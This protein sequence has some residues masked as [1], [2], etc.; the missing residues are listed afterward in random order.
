MT[1]K[2]YGKPGADRELSIGVISVLQ[3]EIDK[4]VAARSA[5]EERWLADLRLFHGVYDAETW[6]KI[7]ED[8]RSKI[9]INKVRVKTNALAAKLWDML[10]PTDDLNW[11]IEATTVPHLTAEAKDAV[12]RAKASQD[13]ADGQ[14]ASQGAGAAGAQAIATAAAT[15][16]ENMRAERAEAVKR[17]KAMQDQISDQ[18]EQSG[19]P[20]QARMGILDACKLGMGVFKGPVVGE[21]KRRGWSKSTSEA[22]GSADYEMT[23]TADDRPT[24]KRIDPWNFYPDMSVSD[25]A[26]G[27]GEFE[28]HTM[29]RKQMRELGRRPGFDRD[30][31]RGIIEKGSYS[32]DIS[33]I[34]NLRLISP[35]YGVADSDSFCVWEYSGPIE[36]KDLASLYAATGDDA[37]LDDVDEH[38]PLDELRV[39]VW[40]CAGEVLKVAPYPLDSGETL[41]SLFRIEPDEGT[42][43]AKGM[44]AILSDVQAAINGAWRMILDHGGATAGPQIVIDKEQIT[45]QDGD[46]A[47]HPFKVWWRDSTMS[48]GGAKPFDQF[49]VVSSLAEMMAIE[50]RLDR[51]MDDISGLPAFS[52]GDQGAGVTKT[53]QGMA[54]LTSAGNTVY[55]K[56]VKHFDDD[57]PSTIIR[58]FYD[59]NMQF[60]KRPEIKGDQRIVARGSSVLLVREMHAQNLI[61]MADRYGQHPVF[62]PML[63][64]GGLPL[65]RQIVKAHMIKADEILLTDEEFKV[66]LTDMAKQAE[67]GDGGL[68]A[69]KMELEK[70]RIAFDREELGVK[71]EL[72]NM[73]ADARRYVAD[74]QHETAM[75]LAAEKANANETTAAFKDKTAA[76][77]R[78]GKE[79]T[80]AVEA[81]AARETGTSSGGSI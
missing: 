14:A 44:P 55:R 51:V 66:M 62:G 1:P 76:E 21:K 15:V 24:A 9:F 31:I 72:A 16:A 54:L 63:R 3:K 35:E 75:M 18:L 59:W 69:A 79:R 11:G 7:K 73:E 71:V 41:Y 80:I 39:I 58:R 57:V 70:D 49:Q 36:A 8:D 38:D 4:R 12:E 81:A 56:I 68:E 30:V 47:P 52:E 29:N 13:G 27:E 60:S 20:A 2:E 46:W 33:H 61:A 78:A 45:P 64:D 77:D 22:A 48:M 10:F 42:V 40:F 34:T 43:F 53:A 67:E 6:A 5:L 74:K 50:Q 25:I 17:A 26:D 32:T 37:G 23:F 65:M 28:R 19:W